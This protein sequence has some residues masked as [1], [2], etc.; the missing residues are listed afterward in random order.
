MDIRSYFSAS[1]SSIQATTSSAN[2]SESDRSSSESDHEPPTKQQCT[3]KTVS[4]ASRR[5]YS[6]SWEKQFSWLVY[7]EDSEGAFCGFAH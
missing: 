3:D 4:L 6:K 5:K 7:N 1:S 2:D